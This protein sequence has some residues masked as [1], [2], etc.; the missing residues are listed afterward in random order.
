[1]FYSRQVIAHNLVNHMT[2]YMTLYM[3]SHLTSHMTN[4]KTSHMTSHMTCYMTCHMS[5]N[6][7]SLSSSDVGGWDT[8]PGDIHFVS[9]GHWYILHP[10]RYVHPVPLSRC[11]RI[12]V[13]PPI[14]L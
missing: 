4:Q 13:R 10:V 12:F 8:E 6:R 1:M 5:L 9:T 14:L 7:L 2:I 11:K 3:A